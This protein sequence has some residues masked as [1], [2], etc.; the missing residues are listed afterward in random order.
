MSASSSSAT[1]RSWSSP[2]PSPLWPTGPMA[3]T[4][5]RAPCPSPTGETRWQPRRVTGAVRYDI[6]FR[7]ERRRSYLDASWTPPRAEPAALGELRRH[8]VLAVDLNA[9]HLAAIVVDPSGNPLGQ[10]A[11]VPLELAGLPSPTRDGRLR[12]AISQLLALAEAVAGWWPGSPP[13]GFRDRLTQMATNRQLAVVAVDPAYTSQWGAQ[14]W[15]LPVGRPALAW[16]P[17]TAV[18]RRQRPPRRGP[19]HRTTW[20]RTASTATGTV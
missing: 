20:T 18:V 6:R 14:H 11:T 13:P 4:G 3:A 17:A 10:P 7:P 19:G 15:Y 1:S 12:A 2:P 9:G 16:P 8:P 5:S